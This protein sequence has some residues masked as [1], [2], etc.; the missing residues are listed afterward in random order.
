[1]K[2][3][4]YLIFNG[5]C[6]AAFRFYEK[7]LG[8]KIELMMTHGDSPISEQ[9]PAEMKNKIMHAR[10]TVNDQ[11]LMGSDSPPEMFEEAKGYYVNIS[12]EEP[13]EA[14]RIFHLLEQDGVVKMPIQETFWSKRF[15]MLVDQFGTHWMINC[16]QPS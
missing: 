3:N 2:L 16:Q 15:G 1:M 11:V 7:C 5:Q 12:V 4:S 10:I 6:E 8:G 9:V 13:L 14:E